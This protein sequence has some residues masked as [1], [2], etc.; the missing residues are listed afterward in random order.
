VL[1]K[2]VSV[3][4]HREIDDQIASVLL[5]TVSHSNGDGVLDDD[6]A[7]AFTGH[8][9]RSSPST[10]PWPA[11][12]ATTPL[13]AGGA[14]PLAEAVSSTAGPP[15]RRRSRQPHS[16]AAVD[17]LRA[18]YDQHRS[19]PY[20]SD[21]EVQRLAMDCQLD[22]RQVQ[23]WLSNRRRMDG[24]TRRRKRPAHNAKPPRPPAAAPAADHVTV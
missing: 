12:P 10:V 22:A 5:R 18:W 17:R 15:R 23:K 9:M 8:E 11:D 20:A 19:R 13:A 1:L 7:A 16:R 6:D 21:L 3:N 4:S 24:N 2:Q 14:A